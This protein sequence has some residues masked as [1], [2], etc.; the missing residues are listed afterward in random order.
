MQDQV[1]DGY[2]LL[3]EIP[4][5]LWALWVSNIKE[6]TL[7]ELL[8]QYDYA[9]AETFTSLDLSD[10]CYQAIST[11]TGFELNYS[12]YPYPCMFVNDTGILSFSFIWP[13]YRNAA[14]TLFFQYRLRLF[15]YQGAFYYNWIKYNS[16]PAYVH[17]FTLTETGLNELAIRDDGITQ[18][19]H[20]LELTI[21]Q[22]F[23][24]L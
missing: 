22:L 12:D 24:P 4:K 15:V 18:E 8:T 20:L 1:A 10:T 9:T 11:E 5:E 3:A 13:H 14:N 7:H 2:I 23:Y 19:S 21:N 6:L 16:D 17:S